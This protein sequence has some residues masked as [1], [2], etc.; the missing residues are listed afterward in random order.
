MANKPSNYA[1]LKAAAEDDLDSLGPVAKKLGITP[2][3]WMLILKE[4]AEEGKKDR[5]RLKAID[6]ITKLLGFKPPERV[7][8]SSDNNGWQVGFGEAED[9]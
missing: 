9:E 4:I 7:F 1:T 5:D 2:E 3:W 8:V 6:L